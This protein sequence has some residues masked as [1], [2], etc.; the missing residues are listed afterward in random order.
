[1]KAKL[2]IDP[3]AFK[4]SGEQTFSLSIKECDL[5]YLDLTFLIAFETLGEIKIIRP[6]NLGNAKWDRLPPINDFGIIYID[7]ED[8]DYQSRLNYIPWVDNL[9]VLNI[10][11]GLREAQFIGSSFSGDDVADRLVDWLLN[12]SIESLKINEMKHWKSLN[13][14][15]HNLSSFKALER[16]N[17]FCQGGNSSMKNVLDNGSIK[18]YGHRQYWQ[19]TVGLA[20]ENCKIQEIKSGAIQGKMRFSIESSNY[21]EYF[22][23][24][25]FQQQ[26]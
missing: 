7:D 9:P 17:I 23:F 8:E 11:T 24:R 16:L 2:I 15:P 22:I 6:S 4:P 18:M 1:M 10:G 14:I 12:S 26:I 5:E 21:L 19:K 25:K 3:N 20:I 13:R